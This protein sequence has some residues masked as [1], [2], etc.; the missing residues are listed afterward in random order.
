MLLFVPASF[1]G[2]RLAKRLVDRI[3]Q[4]HFRKVVAAF[5]FI[6]GVKLLV[7]PG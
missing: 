7:W 4:Q 3:P 5:L 6:V 1:V 2:A